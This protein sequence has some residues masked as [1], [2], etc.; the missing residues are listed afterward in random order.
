M[1]Y[2][3]IYIYIKNVAAGRITQ[4]SGPRFGDLWLTG[5]TTVGTGVQFLAGIEHFS[6]PPRRPDPLLGPTQP[7]LQ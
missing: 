2:I 3:Y 5:W 4:P 7:P 6:L 1:P